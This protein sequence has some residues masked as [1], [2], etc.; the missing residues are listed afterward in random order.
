[1][2]PAQNTALDSEHI[3]INHD[4]PEVQ[5]SV[6]MHVETIHHKMALFATKI[7]DYAVQSHIQFKG[8]LDLNVKMCQEYDQTMET[9]TRNRGEWNLRYENAIREAHGYEKELQQ[10]HIEL[11]Q[12]HQLEEQICEDI[13]AIK[14]YK[15]ELQSRYN[16][17]KFEQQQKKQQIVIDIQQLL[18][19]ISKFKLFLGLELIPTE[20]LSPENAPKHCVTSE[21]DGFINDPTGDGIFIRYTSL[22]PQLSFILCP[23]PIHVTNI[24]LPLP[25]VHLLAQDLSETGNL[26]AF[27]VKLYF[28]HKET[29]PRHN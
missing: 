4:D 16:E 23:S 3:F 2:H 12:Q 14:K 6:A 22:R 17:L 18:S 21:T 27:F 15:V 13:R 7:R 1:M 10:L 5:R 28:L 8:Q 9:Y 29:Y 11:G 20:F 24:N 26:H 19:L 25:N